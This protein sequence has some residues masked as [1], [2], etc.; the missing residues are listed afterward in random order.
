MNTIQESSRARKNTGQDF[1]SASPEEKS[2]QEKDLAEKRF[3]S[4][5]DVFADIVNAVLFHGKA[6]ILPENLGEMK[7]E[8]PFLE[9]V[10][11]STRYRDLSKVLISGRKNAAAAI[12][13]LENQTK[14][15]PD[16]AV[17]AMLYDA[18]TYQYELDHPDQFQKQNRI[19]ICPISTIALYFGVPVWKSPVCLSDVVRVGM[20]PAGYFSDYRIPVVNVRHLDDAQILLFHSDFRAVAF[21]LAHEDQPELFR[22]RNLQ[23]KHGKDFG[24][25]MTARTDNSFYKYAAAEMAAQGKETIMLHSF[26][27]VVEERANKRV[28]EATRQAEQLAKQRAEELAKQRYAEK[29]NQLNQRYLGTAENLF[30]IGEPFEKIHTVMPDIPEDELRQ[31]EA[32]VK[33]EGSPA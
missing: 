28:E 33:K 3:F 1:A 15:E 8:F 31:I 6:V 7:T 26:I 23:I 5:N 13:C 2:R 22:S 16:F 27:D 21:A 24:N 14:I 4:H 10:G 32:R 12:L 29:T 20:L 19:A 11:K 17:R 18:L 30:R 25:L 9:K